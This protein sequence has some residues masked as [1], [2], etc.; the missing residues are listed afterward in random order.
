MRL[1]LVQHGAAL[2]SEVDP[3]R[4]LSESGRQDLQAIAEFL[5]SAGI[6]VERVWHSGKSRAEQTAHLLAK[7]VLPRGRIEEVGGIGPHDDVAGFVSDADVWEQDILVV[8]HLPF[9]SRLVAW[10]VE[11]DPEREVV[12]YVPGS[13]VCLERRDADRWMLLWMIRPELLVHH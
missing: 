12:G 2:A 8:G 5:K 6:R 4:P 1:Y 7:A 13:V 11:G 3:A 9:L 10:L